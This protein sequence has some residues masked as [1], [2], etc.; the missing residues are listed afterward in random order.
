[1]KYE[2]KNNEDREV[3]FDYINR[4]VFIKYEVE[5]ILI[6]EFENKHFEFAINGKFENRYSLEDSDTNLENELQKMEKSVNENINRRVDSIIK[7]LQ[8]LEKFGYRLQD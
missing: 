3:R 2:T 1:M 4:V 7:K 8:T 5:V 6:V